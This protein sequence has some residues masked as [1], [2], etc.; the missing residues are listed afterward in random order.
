MSAKNFR[1]RSPGIRVQEIDQSFVEAPTVSEVGPVIVGRSL[2][3]PILKPV[4]VNSVAEFIDVF[5]EPSPGGYAGG[6]LWRNENT[7]APHYG[8]YAALAYLRNSAPITFIRLGGISSPGASG[9]GLAGW[10]TTGSVEPNASLASDAGAYGLWLAPSASA[11]DEHGTGSLA[12]VFYMSKGAAIGLKVAAGEYK[13][14]RLAKFS[15]KLTAAKLKLIVSASAAAT[16][17]T[18]A[19][20]VSELGYTSGASDHNKTFTV[21]LDPSDSN[22]I[23]KALNTSPLRTYKGDDGVNHPHPYFLGETFEDVIKAKEGSESN[24]MAFIA[25]L[26]SGSVYKGDYRYDF[27]EAKTGWV[28]SQDTGLNTSFDP[29]DSTPQKLFRLV[30]LNEGRWASKNIKISIAKISYTKIDNAAEPYPTFSVQVRDAKDSDNSP[31]ILEEFNDVTLNPRSSNFIAAVIGDQYIEYDKAAR[32]HRVF[33]SYPNNSRYIR[34]DVHPD[35]LYGTADPELVPFG[36]LGPA[37]RKKFQI[38]SGSAANTPADATYV[39]LQTSYASEGDSSLEWGGGDFI[40]SN[41]LANTFTASLE[42]PDY[43]LRVSASNSSRGVAKNGYFGVRTQKNETSRFF[44]DNYYDLSYPLEGGVDSWNPDGTNTVHTFAFSL[45]DVKQVSSSTTGWLDDAAYEAGNRKSA[46]AGKKSIS[47]LGSYYKANGP[48]Q[49]ATALYTNSAGWKTVIDA[50]YNKFTMPMHGGF[51][52]V[53][54]TK[55]NPFSNVT[56]T[57]GATNDGANNYAWYSVFAA[58]KALK[59]PEF[60]DYDVAAVP[61]VWEKQLNKLMADQCLERGDALAVVDL[62]SGY[63]PLEETKENATTGVNTDLTKL[64]SVSAAVNWRRNDMSDLVHSYACTF[65]PWVDISDPRTNGLVSVPPSVAMLGVFGRVK[66]VSD[67]WFAPAGFNRGGLSD[68]LSGYPVVNVKDRLTSN[69]RDELYDNGINPIASF[70]SEGVVVFGQKTLQLER[71]SLDRI[72]VRRLMIYLKRQI[73]R[74]ASSLLFEPNVPDTWRNFTN[75]AEE[76]LQEVQDGL[77]IEEYRF[78]LDETTT[79]PDLV[80]QNT[81]YAK[82]L[83]KP[84]RAIEFIALDFVLT[85]SGV[86]FPE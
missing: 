83:I 10:Q 66:Q 47:Q 48:G 46:V 69:E 49:T 15:G 24:T 22:F 40:A 36:F 68:G 55:K 29:I 61:G 39:N 85:N 72:N 81:L 53:D 26:A 4:T 54:I 5:G 52:G 62:D 33:G 17:F 44:S 38:I 82:L 86:D 23:R 20:L 59:D 67:V 51:D 35:V 9:T 60:I 7:T 50:G 28:F 34:V 63:R 42:W 12:A 30:G 76:I 57:G 56:L 71:S 64:G 37:R 16:D 45:D 79:T 80:D 75:D 74:V 25:P 11:G 70:P 43:A 84:T 32:K 8:A 2:E 1:F 21:T 77:G 65:Y 3:G 31:A 27:Q 73:S 18:P 41:V 14:K 78:I 19:S 6:D 13:T 58:I